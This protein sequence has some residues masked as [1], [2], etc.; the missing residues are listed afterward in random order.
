MSNRSVVTKRYNVNGSNRLIYRVVLG[1]GCI[2]STHI[3]D[4]CGTTH[5]VYNM[6]TMETV[7]SFSYRDAKAMF[8]ELTNL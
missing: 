1:E 4:G 8:N 6:I 5:K 3:V 7:E 2:W